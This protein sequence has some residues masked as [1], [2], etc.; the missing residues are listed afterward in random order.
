[1]NLRTQSAISRLFTRERTERVHLDDSHPIED[2]LE[3]GPDEDGPIRAHQVE[4]HRVLEVWVGHGVV[5]D[6]REVSRDLDLKRRWTVDR[7]AP[8][9]LGSL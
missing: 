5:N 4:D 8:A 6:G 7:R 1:M 3:D 2:R 9:R